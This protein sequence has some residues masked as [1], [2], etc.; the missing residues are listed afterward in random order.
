MVIFRLIGRPG[1]DNYGMA[2]A[3]SVI[4]AAL[5]AAVM[6]AAELVRPRE[7]EL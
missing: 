4:L 7:A 2:M 3:A 1:A 6:A 5:T